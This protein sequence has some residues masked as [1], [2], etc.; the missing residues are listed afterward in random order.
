MVLQ[1]LLGSEEGEWD[2]EPL[3]LHG[4]ATLLRACYAEPGIDI[5]YGTE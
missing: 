5:G 3:T 2:G 1:G 4:S